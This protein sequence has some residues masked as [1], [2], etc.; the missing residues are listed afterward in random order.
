MS[1]PKD[2]IKQFIKIYKK[3]IGKELSFEDA[4]VQANKF[5]NFLKLITKPQNK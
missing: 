3:E 1:L 5:F 2:A 4:T